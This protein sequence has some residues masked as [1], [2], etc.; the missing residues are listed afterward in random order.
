MD[1]YAEALKKA[2]KAAHI[3]QIEMAEM[4]GVSVTSIHYAESGT[5]RITLPLLLK[6]CEI[7][8]TTPDAILGICQ[9][10]DREKLISLYC[11]MPDKYKELFL[12]TGE[13]IAE[14]SKKHEMIQK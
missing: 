5:R 8:S 3:S 11:S 12:K 10:E 9:G 13:V 6:Y 1:K 4:C 14:H 2:R 7:L